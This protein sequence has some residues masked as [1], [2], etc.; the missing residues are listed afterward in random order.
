MF[1]FS[2]SYDSSL[3]YSSDLYQGVKRMEI[4]KSEVGKLLDIIWKRG[5]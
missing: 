3:V 2:G 4:V 1:I 5:A